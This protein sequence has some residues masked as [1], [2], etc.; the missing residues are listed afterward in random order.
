MFSE[1][2][3]QSQGPARSKAGPSSGSETPSPSKKE[4]TLRVSN[5][6]RGSIPAPMLESIMKHQA[7][8]REYVHHE[9]RLW[10]TSNKS[11]YAF[12]ATLTNA[13]LSDLFE[14]VLEE[15]EN[16]LDTYAWRGSWTMSSHHHR[17][18]KKKKKERKREK[19]V[20]SPS[21]L[22]FEFR[23]N[24]YHLLKRLKRKFFLSVSFSPKEENLDCIENRDFQAFLFLLTACF[25]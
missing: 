10:N 25:C 14:E 4:G 24:F 1:A 21:L 23:R 11:Q 20:G 6:R 15:V 12:A 5:V 3:V 17:E 22:V 2:F 9:E 18:Q 8:Q 7:E 19:V 16:T 13:L